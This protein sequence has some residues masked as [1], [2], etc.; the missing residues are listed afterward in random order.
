MEKK[1]PR[2]LSSPIQVLFFDVDEVVMALAMVSLALIFSYWPVYL[3]AIAVPWAYRRVKKD[4][5][6]GF[7]WHS[8]YYMGLVE[9]KGYP[10]TFEKEFYE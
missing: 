4:K 1:F 8:L 7:F 6:R 2:Y 5:A 3:L 10:I 9:I